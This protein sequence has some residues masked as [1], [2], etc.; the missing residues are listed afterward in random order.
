MAVPDGPSA[1]AV[2]PRLD[3][4]LRRARVVKQSTSIDPPL[5]V[6]ELVPESEPLIGSAKGEEEVLSLAIESAARAVFYANLVSPPH[7]ISCL[8]LT[9]V[10][11][12]SN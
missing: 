12:N 7:F 4:L 11:I 10:G 3:S 1:I 8:L 2:A 5:P 6:S 9:W